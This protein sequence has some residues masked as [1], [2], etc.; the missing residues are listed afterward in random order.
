M[1]F[2]IRLFA[3]CAVANLA[4]SAPVQAEVFEMQSGGNFIKI[5]SPHWRP[6]PHAMPVSGVPIPHTVNMSSI[7]MPSTPSGIPMSRD[8]QTAHIQ[9]SIQEAAQRYGVDPVLLDALAWQESRYNPSVRSSAGA[10]GVMQ[11][12]PG[13]ARELGVSDPHDVQQNIAAGAAYLRQQLIR[14]DNNVP[15]AL[16]AYNAGPGAVIKY[17]GIPPYGETQNYVRVIMGR[18]SAVQSANMPK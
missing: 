1:I 2:L 14:F 5:S 8:P 10:F 7:S 17:G 15:L 12:M 4:L 3:V 6:E 11:L 18:V 9:R 16:A 13:T